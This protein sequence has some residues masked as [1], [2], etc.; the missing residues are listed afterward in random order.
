MYKL[1]RHTK[2]Y[3]RRTMKHKHTPNPATLKKLAIA[4]VI[5]AIAIFCYVK[6]QPHTQEAKQTIQLEHKSQQL[7]STQIDLEKSKVRDA[8]TQKKLDETNKQLQ[9]VQKQLEAKRATA[10]A[11]AAEL[12]VSQAPQAPA[13][14]PSGGGTNCGSDPYLAEIYK[15]ESG[16]CPTKW[17]GQTFCPAGFAHIYDG[18]ISDGWRGYGLCQSTPAIKMA[19]SGADWAT[20]WV[21]QNAWCTQYAIVRYGSTAAAWAHWQVAHNW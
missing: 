4:F 9:E 15:R 19:N 5:T 16:C 14:S 1:N 11:Y 6:L 21:T 18:D 12:P 10:T 17:Q 3:S 2:P 20:N 8:D 7:K 13:A